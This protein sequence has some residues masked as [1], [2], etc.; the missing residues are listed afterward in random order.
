MERPNSA[1]GTRKNLRPSTVAQAQGYE[2][3][4]QRAD[5]ILKAPRIML[6]KEGIL[7]QDEKITAMS[8]HKAYQSLC[9]KIRPKM[10][11]D[12]SKLLV[13]F[14]IPLGELAL[15][16]E[17][18]KS[19]SGEGAT[20]ALSGKTEGALEKELEK[21]SALVEASLANQRELQCTSKKL[22]ETAEDIRRSAQDVNRNLTVAS[23]TSNKLTNTVSTYKEMLLTAPQIQQNESRNR[24]RQN[25]SVDPRITRDME[26]K[27]K[28]VLV[29]VLNNKVTNQSLDELR[30]KLNKLIMESEDPA[31]PKSDANVQQVVKMRNGGMILQFN[32]REAAEW[33]R[34]PE[35]ELMLLPKIDSTAQVKERSFQILVPR[36]P[37]TF[38]TAKEEHLRELEEQN[39]LY[40]NRIKKA[41]WIKPTYRRALGQQFTH[42]ALTVSTPEDANLLIRDGIYICSN[43][44][45]PRKMKQEPKQC[46]KCRKWGH[47]AA[48]CLAEKDV[49]GNCG[50]DHRTKDCPTKDKRY[51]ASCKNETHA[52]W[53]RVCPEFQ[54]RVERMDENHPENA[55]AYFPT[56]EDWTMHVRPHRLELD[57]K[58]PAKYAVASLPPPSAAGERQA[59]TRPVGEKKRKQQVRRKQTKESGP[60]DDFVE[61]MKNGERSEGATG[62]EG[63]NISEVYSDDEVDQHLNNAYIEE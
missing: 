51:C 13:A 20:K 16:S 24:G 45:Y 11:P 50:E 22:E 23:D 63:S 61:R 9:E 32:T 10:Q 19:K 4:K 17:L 35:V 28:Q 14:L 44:I 8:I 42:L 43:K 33:F 34:Q 58:F 3:R 31:K 55:L 21:L 27:A 29:D 36:V 30:N 2:D 59:T 12:I 53:D 40:A 15:N 7:K 25:A 47:F 48:D 49:C 57:E 56:E 62:K 1:A 37:V 52:S 60:M 5:A 39:N 41:K 54:R 38:D 26:R 46:M 18:E 6:D